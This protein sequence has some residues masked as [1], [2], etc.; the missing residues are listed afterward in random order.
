ME[1]RKKCVNET[2]H[3]LETRLQILKAHFSSILTFKTNGNLEH[4]LIWFIGVVT[5][6]AMF[7]VLSVHH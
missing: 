4:T 5:T 2:R 7:S 6:H 3:Y 1:S